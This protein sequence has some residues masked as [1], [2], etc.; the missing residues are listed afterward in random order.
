MYLRLKFPF[1][2]KKPLKIP[3]KKIEK[4]YFVA[5]FLFFSVL[6]LD[7]FSFFLEYFRSN[8]ILLVLIFSL[9]SICLSR[10]NC[11]I[12]GPC[13]SLMTSPPPSI[14]LLNISFLVVSSILSIFSFFFIS[15]SDDISS[16]FAIQSL[17]K[18]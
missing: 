8:S 14:N 3:F 9:N 15:S 5:L 16:P 1:I 11:I 12:F 2:V 7:F 18:N 13:F 4:G 6:L 17:L 10:L